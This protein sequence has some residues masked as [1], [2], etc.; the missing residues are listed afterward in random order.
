MVPTAMNELQNKDNIIKY[1]LLSNDIDLIKCN[2]CFKIPDKLY[3][4]FKKECIS[5]SY[6]IYCVNRIEKEQKRCPF[7]RINFDIKDIVENKQ[8]NEL[9]SIYYKYNVLI[10]NIKLNIET[11]EI[12]DKKACEV[13]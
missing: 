2:V 8:K 7:T 12:S 3:C 13:H 9:I 5:Y 6:C 11:N 10:K 4:I 1:V